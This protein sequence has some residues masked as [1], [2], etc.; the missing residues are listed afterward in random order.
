MSYYPISCGNVFTAGQYN[1]MNDGLMLRT[2]VSN[3]YT[4]NCGP[5][6]TGVNVPSNL[7]G[8]IVPTGLNLTFTDNS[9]NETGFI[10]ERS[11]TSATEGYTAIGG[12][13]PNITT[14]LDQS[15][16]AFTTYYYRVKASNSTDQYST[17]FTITTA[18]NYC[19]PTYTTSC[20]TIGVVIDDFILKEGT[21]SIINN[22]DSNCSPGN[23]GNF[24]GTN[25][26]VTA[27]HTYTFTARALTGGGSGT[28]FDQ[29]VTVW[30][31]YNQ[32]GFF[33][34]S[35]R[36]YR[37]DSASMPRMNPTA[38]RSFTIPNT[39]S[40][41][42]RI[43]IRSSFN[44]G[45]GSAVTNPCINL[46]YG[47]TEDYSLNVTSAS[48]PSITTGTV[49]PIPVC[50]GQ[51]ISVPFTT[52]NLSSSSYVV[53]LSDAAG[54]NFANITTVGTSSP[55][56]ATIPFGTATGSGYKVRVNSVSPI[57]TGSESGV[58]TINAIPAAPTATTPINY[59]QNQ[60]ASP[61]TATGSNL[62][63]Y[64]VASGGVGNTTAPTP[65]MA[66]AGTTNYWISQTINSCESSRTQINVIVTATPATPT[67]TTPINY[68]QNQTAT[69][70]TATGSN[71]LWY[72][73]SGG[74]G[75]ST[76]PTPVT[77]SAG[78]TNYWV[79]QT[80]SGC[81]SN[82]TQIS[83]IV[84]AILAAPTPVN[85]CQNQTASPLTATGSNLKWYTVASGGVGNTTAPTPSTASAGTTNYW[86]SQAINSC[87]SSR[88]QINVIVTAT[89]AAPTATTPINYCQNQT[90]SPLTATGSNL[91]WYTVASGRTGSAT[92]PTP[93]TA[94]AATT[95]Y[96]VSQT[97]SSC[98]SNRTQIS[99]IVTA[100]P[101]APTAPT[102]VNYCQ[103]QTASPLTATGSNLL[104]Y[105]SASGGIGS[106]SAPTPSTASIGTTSYWVSQTISGCESS[107]T[108]INV[109]VTATPTAPTATTPIN[110]FQNQ[111]AIPLT[112]TG[113]NLLWYT[114]ASGGVG[115]TT[116][117]IPS[118]A[119]AGT[120]SYWVSQ[121]V[122]GCESS[123]TQ[124]NVIVSATPTVPTA[125]TPVN[126][127]QG[128]TAVP[129]NASGTN[130]KWY[131]VSSGG[132]G[133]AV[134]PTPSTATIGT[135][136]HYVSQTNG[137]CESARTTIQV[138]INITGSSSVVAC[139]TL[140]VYLE[141]NWNGT[142]MTTTLNQQGLLPG[143]TPVSPFGV[144]TP[145]GQ[146]Y[147]AAPSNYSGTETVSSY[148]SDVVD[149]VLVSL[150]TNISDANSVVYKSAALLRKTGT[151]TLV[152]ACPLLNP[153]QSYS[154]VVEHRSHIGAASHQPIAIVAN[155]IT[156]DFTLQQ[157]YI[158]INV[159][160]S[161][162]Q[163]VGSVYCLFAGDCSKA[164]FS[165]IN[166][167][168]ATIWRTDNG[169][170][171]RYQLTDFNLDG[172]INAND[173]TIWRRNN[174]KFFGITF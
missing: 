119:S 58:F 170:F 54:N 134:A 32:N 138:N 128:Q 20:S 33:E 9:S 57:V 139:P 23:Y 144:A 105:T 64:T 174:G 42:V 155:K 35:E 110:Y 45:S 107:R 11:T 39:V 102:P 149:W 73:A 72:T 7:T 14:Y 113:S 43:R 101:A 140:K 85:Y 126:Y 130:L 53:Q 12:I 156:Y 124:I 153:S 88:T 51:T 152:S 66:S 86:I 40:G 145:A 6:V 71:L 106:S 79:S 171:P 160:S 147:K 104:W 22:L 87:E 111:T 78:T 48:P 115:N 123:R 49:T 67:A 26:N 36:V 114:V 5:T 89:P 141:G 61:L 59:C 69:P 70:L 158:P 27:G 127:I 75:N 136:N 125:T 29:Q 121:T 108:Q 77:S 55:L 28:Y 2:D 168:D 24:T 68:C 151:V 80:I 99:V 25:Y 159:P 65:S 17:V 94:S 1:R 133:N 47:E 84:T 154:V 10:I 46:T 172:N 83:A 164:S 116:A 137:G 3:Q 103:N 167:N 129:L 4:L 150:R 131:T 142:E 13:A 21:T 157:S 163:K 135:F 8:S 95:G 34:F 76:A 169:K 92:A 91:L 120:T 117:P 112:A 81:E 41:I 37:S 19:I 162:Q 18:L 62:K 161:G 118:S 60:T 74:I 63:W 16:T 173:D 166:A 44:S 143:Q 109:S 15:T 30:L 93:S 90:A 122:S 146:P 96:L 56:I 165:E 31:D 148:D 82:R 97:I 98:E 132:T 38:V 100:I 52:S 50:A